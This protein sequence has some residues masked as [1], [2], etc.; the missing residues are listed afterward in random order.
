MRTAAKTLVVP[1]VVLDIVRNAMTP[2]RRREIDGLALDLYFGSNWRVGQVAKSPAGKRCADPLCEPYEIANAC[3]LIERAIS[4]A[5]DE[6]D[7]L[8]LE[9]AVRLAS[10]FAELLQQGDHFLAAGR[11]CE[12]TIALLNAESDNQQ[13]DLLRYF[14]ARAVRMQGKPDQSIALF[15]S[16]DRSH[17]NRDQR[18]QIDLSMALAYERMSDQGQA[19]HWASEVL[20]EGKS[21]GIAVQAKSILAEQLTDIAMRNAELAKLEQRARR[22][23]AKVAANNIA[24]VRAVHAG[25]GSDAIEHLDRVIASAEMEDDFYNGCRAIVRLAT[26]RAR[27]DDHHPDEE[28]ARLIRAYTHLF[29]EREDSLFSRAH[30]ALWKVFQATGEHENLLRLFRHTSLIWRLQGTEENED[31]YLA[32]VARF[33]ASMATNSDIARELAYYRSRAAA[34]LERQAS[35]RTPLLPP[36]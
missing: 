25:S 16:I 36:P 34:S 33:S 1:R 5:R 8:K 14:M 29:N 3:A 13:I 31:P 17:M 30:A 2:E 27:R 15:R 4:Q 6:E 26:L 9:A 11:L 20:K 24:L 7:Q 23:K 12:R 21:D 18:R 32:E 10:I 22:I 28:V 19:A 35:T